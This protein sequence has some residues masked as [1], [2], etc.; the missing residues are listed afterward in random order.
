MEEN[1]ALRRQVS[2]K[3][4]TIASQKDEI[5]KLLDPLAYLR[6][7]QFGQMSEKH[8]PLDPAQLTLFDQQ[9]MTEEEKA[10]LAQDVEKAEEAITYSVTRK[11]KPSRKPLTTVS[12]PSR[13][14]TSILME[15]PTRMGTSS[16]SMSRLAPKSPELSKRSLQVSISRIR[17]AIRSF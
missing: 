13:K 3:D 14:S 1:E 10:A 2:E 11:A 4:A 8:L 16:P 9:Q 5:A 12:F 15:R 17:Y 7:K 6:K